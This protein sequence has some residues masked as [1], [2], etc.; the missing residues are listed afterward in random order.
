MVKMDRRSVTENLVP[1][2]KGMSAQDAVFILENAGLSVSL[3]GRGAIR[4]QSI[5][6]GQRIIKGER[7]ILEL[8]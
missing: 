1:N 4:Q 7:I 5:A 3:R 8:S 2:V 6:P